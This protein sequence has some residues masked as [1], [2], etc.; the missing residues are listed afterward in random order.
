MILLGGI[1]CD[2]PGAHDTKN[3]STHPALPWMTDGG[4]RKSPPVAIVLHTTS[5]TRGEELHTESPPSERAERYA[6]YQAGTARDVSWDFTV[7]LDGTIVQHN[8]PSGPCGGRKVPW[9]SWHAGSANGWTLGIETVQGA[10]GVVYEAQ[11]RVV[12]ALVSFLCDH[13]GIPKR[14]PCDSDGRPW[15]A[16]IFEVVSTKREGR[17]KRWP[18]VLGHCNVTTPDSRGP[19]DPGDHVRGALLD[20][21]FERFDITELAKR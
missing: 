8:D 17:Q 5:G 7:D 15:S 20:A 13:Y 2:V 9:Y 14:V 10:H 1:A 12:A 6:K 16:P 3:P 19:W 4:E 21:C 18:G 11:L